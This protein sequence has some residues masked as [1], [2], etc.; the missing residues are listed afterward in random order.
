MRRSMKTYKEIYKEG[1]IVALANDY[2]HEGLHV[3]LLHYV[4]GPSKWNVSIC[5]RSFEGNNLEELIKDLAEY[6]LETDSAC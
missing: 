4:D 3:E 2:C 6:M 5:S 1:G